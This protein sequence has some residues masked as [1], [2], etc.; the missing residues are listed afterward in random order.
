M[1]MNL[2]TKITFTRI[3]FIIIMMVAL[4]TLEIICFINPSLIP[5]KAITYDLGNGVKLNLVYIIVCAFFIIASITDWLDG[6][7][8]RK[9]N[10]VTDL[11]K[12]LD[13]VADKLLVNC[14]IIFLCVPQVYAQEQMAFPLFCAIIIIAR[15]IVVDMLRF[16]AAKKDIVI[17]A[18]I[19][20]KLKTIFQMVTIPLVLLNGF[21]F[22]LF[23]K[24]LGGYFSITH[25]F[26]YLTTLVS[27]ISGI[28]YVY[29]YRKAFI[30][31]K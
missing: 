4:A 14:T 3:I 30:D 28:I 8:A 18:N 27:L 22:S 20:G 9:Y 12:F 11:G 24:V 10:L 5:A 31:E 26:V 17:A 19:F 21:P 16:V 29:N 15:D 7:I 6:V 23:D 1:K 13:P 2:P 25:I